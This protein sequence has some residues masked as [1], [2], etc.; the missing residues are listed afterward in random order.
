MKTHQRTL[1][2]LLLAFF[3]TG[4]L[5]AQI[6]AIDSLK[7]IPAN[8]TTND[9]VKLISYS[10]FPSGGCPLTSSSVNISGATITVHVSHTLGGATVLCKSTDTLA[11]GKLSA[12]A[13]ELHYHLA[14]TAPPTTYDIDTSNFTV[15]QASGLQLIGHSEQ[16]LIIY[17][18]PTT[19]EIS[20]DLKT[21]SVK[22]HDI[23]FY[24]VQGQIV[25]AAKELS[26]IIT[27]DISDL[28]DGVYF[29]VITSEHNRRWAQKIIKSNR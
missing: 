14:D 1:A 29:I 2:T 18:N 17:P 11:I 22:R 10:T 5:K 19:T 15:Q 16:E 21:H 9:S 23:Y 4:N 12:G 27:I 8:P 25:K 24:S 13:Y 3:L 26:D 28:T 7:I 20:L 6:P